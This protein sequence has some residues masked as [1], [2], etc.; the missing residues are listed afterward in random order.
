M[1]LT[2]TQLAALRKIGPNGIPFFSRKGIRERT[3]DKLEKAGLIQYRRLDGIRLRVELT[4]AGQELLAEHRAQGK[5]KG[6]IY[7]AR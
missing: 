1:K 2:D 4:D 5:S 6:V 7:A 3:L